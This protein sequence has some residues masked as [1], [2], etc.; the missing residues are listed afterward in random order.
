M[1]TAAQHVTAATYGYRFV[2]AAVAFVASHS[3][4]GDLRVLAS[5]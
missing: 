1:Q 4:L 5:S 2:L 3:Q